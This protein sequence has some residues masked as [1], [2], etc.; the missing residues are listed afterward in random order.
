MSLSDTLK[1]GNIETQILGV[2]ESVHLG[3]FQSKLSKRFQVQCERS[4]KAYRN[5]A[6]RVMDPKTRSPKTR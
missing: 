2:T 3:D 4:H 5:G 1:V 6:T